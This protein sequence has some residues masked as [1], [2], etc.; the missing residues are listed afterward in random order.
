MC[1]ILYISTND[2]VHNSLIK[3]YIV[4]NTS[5]KVGSYLKFVNDK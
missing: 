1:N 3:M 2:T 4:Q 5:Y